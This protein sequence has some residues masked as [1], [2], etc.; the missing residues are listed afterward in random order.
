VNQRQI[1][2]NRNRGIFVV[3]VSAVVAIAIAA[4]L[5]IYVS[6]K[7]AITIGDQG[8]PGETAASSLDTLSATTSPPQPPDAAQSPTPQTHS[9]TQ[10]SPQMPTQG[11]TQPQSTAPTPETDPPPT[12]PYPVTLNEVILDTTDW[13]RLDVRWANGTSTVFERDKDSPVWTMQSRDGNFRMV[14]PTY[15]FEGA[16][17]TIRFPTSSN[18]Y[19]I[20]DDGTGSFGNETLTWEFETSRTYSRES[21]SVANLTSDLAQI[22]D[23]DLLIVLRVYWNNGETTI[24]YKQDNGTWFMKSRGGSFKLVEPS[25]RSNEGVDYLDFPTSSA[26]Y[27]FFEGG[28]G[29]YSGE[30]FSWEYDFYDG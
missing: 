11:T 9:T 24:M 21:V 13:I 1:H 25:F 30:V 2:G 10:A 20:L 22:I 6:S 8:V 12:L 17:L 28:D 15:G 14:E 4:V 16:A 7:D 3:V 27:E 5:W 23:R 18:Y 26:E 29:W 19:K